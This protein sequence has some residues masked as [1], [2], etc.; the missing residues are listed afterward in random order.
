ML[1]SIATL[2][3]IP[4]LGDA[5]AAATDAPLY[6]IIDGQRVEVPPMCAYAGIV[7]SRLTEQLIVHNH[8]QS[9]KPGRV[10]PEFLF[11]LPLGEGRGQSRRPD[12]AF[13]SFER[14]PA[15]PRLRPREN[16][17]DVVPDLAVEVISPSDLAEDQLKK[18]V[19]YFQAGVRLVWV[20]YPELGFVYVYRSLKAIEVLMEA[21]VLRGDP[22]LPGFSMPVN[23][24]FDPAPPAE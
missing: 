17:W 6:E 1:M 3:E 22:V 16:A 10:L 11:R 23:L 19:E 8:D 4:D 21:D 5:E 13:V 9:P 7:T 15:D 14:A 18:V 24:L 2:P 20:V 12:I